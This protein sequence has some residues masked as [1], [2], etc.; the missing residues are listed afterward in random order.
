MLVLV[1]DEVCKAHVVSALSLHERRLRLTGCQLPGPVAELL[2]ALSADSDG[3]VRPTVAAGVLGSDSDG[4]L[5]DSAELSVLLHTSERTARRM[6]ASG[7]LRSVTI[8][9]KRLTRAEDLRHY[10]EQLPAN[11]NNKITEDKS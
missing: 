3:Q 1:V 2:T 8:A 5:F 6:Q 10:I 11:G 9:G 7:E 4:V